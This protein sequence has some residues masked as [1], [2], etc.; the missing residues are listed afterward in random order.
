MFAY[1]C[2]CVL[3]VG[4]V[5]QTHLVVVVVVVVVMVV[6]GVVITIIAARGNS[7]SCRSS[8]NRSVVQFLKYFDTCS[9]G[10]NFPVRQ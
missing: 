7:R 10:S 6:T 8:H 3:R 4:L 1:C 9:C 5:A 2:V